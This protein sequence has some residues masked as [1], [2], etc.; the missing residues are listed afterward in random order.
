L[1][2]FGVR[3]TMKRT[4]LLIAVFSVLML[5][6][7]E[8]PKQDTQPAAGAGSGVVSAGSAAEKAD[9]A[10]SPGPPEEEGG[11]A[12]RTEEKPSQNLSFW[13]IN[14]ILRRYGEPGSYPIHRNGR[15]IVLLQDIDRNG[16]EDAVALFV[17]V[18]EFEMADTEQVGSVSRLYDESIPPFQCTLR[19]FSQ[20]NFRLH[21]TRT[22]DLGV[23]VGFSHLE[24]IALSR[25]Q[26]HPYGV[27]AGFISSEGSVEEWLFI[28]PD[29]VNRFTLRE[30]FT[31][32]FEVRDVDGDGVTD[33]LVFRKS[34]EE[35]T[36]YETFI[37]W[38]RWNGRN[39]EEYETINVVRNLKEFLRITGEYVVE[40]EWS[41]LASHALDTK[42]SSL[43]VA[44]DLTP[45]R[46]AEGI[47]APDPSRGEAGEAPPVHTLDIERVIFP[48]IIENP[49]Q[50]METGDFHFTGNVKIIAQEGD[51]LYSTRIRMTE[52]PFRNQQFSFVIN[53]EHLQN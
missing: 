33:V 47:F 45:P 40:G 12:D 46:I 42:E 32:R 48:E 25:S 36:G 15:I 28:F 19:V 7:A 37:I 13:Q 27:S 51:F 39:F 49:F 4:V 9:P 22:V 53:Y 30:T 24:E 21:P 26:S 52:N 5:S 16:T 17:G 14:S 20:E 50:R 34:F 35:G 38:Y 11:E 18:E 10:G 29:R 2:V 43:A 6:C 8:L 3:I 31:T 41:L 23:R 44:R 1:V